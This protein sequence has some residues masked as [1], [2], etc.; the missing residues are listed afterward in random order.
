MPVRRSY[1]NLMHFSDGQSDHREKA[2]MI[3]TDE[4]EISADGKHYSE[5][6]FKPDFNLFRLR[7]NNYIGQFWAIRK[8]ILEQAGKFDP[9][10]DGAQDY[11]MLLRCSEQVEN[12]VHIPKILCH[13]MKAE[14]LITEEQEKKTGKQAERHWRSITAGRRFLQQRNLQTRRD[15]TE[16]I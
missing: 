6:E 11:D 14:N 13:S 3:Y 16:A 7:E 2:D 12:I 9:E 5:P 4:D 15:G 1:L 10:Y 8:E